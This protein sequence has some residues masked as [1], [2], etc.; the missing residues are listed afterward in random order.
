MLSLLLVLTTSLFT[1]IAQTMLC[2]PQDK[3]LFE[4]IGD[5]IGNTVREAVGADEPVAVAGEMEFPED[6]DEAKSS[7]KERGRLRARLEA[8]SAV[9]RDWLTARCELTNEQQLTLNELATKVLDEEFA[10]FTK[11]PGRQM[12]AALDVS[13]PVLFTLQKEAR[14]PAGGLRSQ[15]E[16]MAANQIGAGA[17]FESALLERTR[18]E[19]LTPDQISRLNDALAERQEFIASAYVKYLCAMIDRELFLTSDQLM[20][21]LQFLESLPAARKHPLYSFEPYSYYMPYLPIAG[22]LKGNTPG[23]ILNREQAD[24]VSDLISSADGQRNL[25][26]MSNTGPEEWQR[27]ITQAGQ[28]GRDMLLRAAAL[29]VSSLRQEYNL[30]PEQAEQLFL[31]GKG[32]AVQML[33]D[34]KESAQQTIAQME[35]QMAQF[36]GNFGFGTQTLD[37][38][39]LDS[40]EIWTTALTSVLAN[41]KGQGDNR[42][43]Q[44][45]EATAGAMLALLDEELWLTPEQRAA[46]QP[47]VLKSLPV[48][49]DPAQHQQY[50]RELVLLAHPLLRSKPDERNRVLS[51]PQQAVWTLMLHHFQWQKANNYVQIQLHNG[52]GSFGFMLSTEGYDP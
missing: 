37:I 32:A 21:F 11:R 2:L 1:A 38:S 3:S 28:Q 10:S 15:P 36:Q 16:F 50:I 31:A 39:G 41:R 17:D 19:L 9:M 12:N 34:W 48:S 26:F 49:T 47:M 18:K 42:R 35:Q 8:R 13:M 25:T 23:A 33:E 24:R 44:L 22:L 52:G 46:L 29:R 27:Q 43:A 7:E 5:L 30:S 45:R 51:E 20:Q 4:E 40:N 14:K 6:E